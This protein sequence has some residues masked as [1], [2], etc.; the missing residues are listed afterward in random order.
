MSNNT[1]NTLVIH[2]FLIFSHSKKGK[3]IL[4]NWKFVT[5]LELF[6]TDIFW[7]IYHSLFRYKNNQN[8]KKQTLCLKNERIIDDF[9]LIRKFRL[10]TFV[11]SSFSNFY[12]ISEWEIILSK[13][14]LASRGR[15]SELSTCIGYN[16][17]IRENFLGIEMVMHTRLFY[18]HIMMYFPWFYIVRRVHKIRPIGIS[19]GHYFFDCFDTRRSKERS[20]YTNIIQSFA[21]HCTPRS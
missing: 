21:L 2:T 20:R 3:D 8:R 7:T 10:K 11:L 5:K 12:T 6:K 16:K 4:I 15:W 19:L 9:R 18:L 14:L 17:K 13:L 1:V